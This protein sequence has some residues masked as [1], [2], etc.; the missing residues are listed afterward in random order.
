MRRGLAVVR[1]VGGYAYKY[2]NMS[3][4]AF[5]GSGKKLSM[6]DVKEQLVTGQCFVDHKWVRCKI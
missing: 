5:P 2:F 6:N 4:G 3:N 1:P